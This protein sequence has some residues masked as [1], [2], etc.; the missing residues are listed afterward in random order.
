[1]Y[2]LIGD[3]RVLL[4]TLYLVS[5]NFLIAGNEEPPGSFS[6]LIAAFTITRTLGKLFLDELFLATVVLLCLAFF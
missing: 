4:S 6:F 5:M 3:E 1:M 2:S